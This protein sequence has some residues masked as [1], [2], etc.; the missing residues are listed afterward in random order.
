MS[1][2]AYA[3]RATSREQTAASLAAVVLPKSNS[4]LFNFDDA[5]E[6]FTNFTGALGEVFNPLDPSNGMAGLLKNSSESPIAAIKSTDFA[7]RKTIVD[8]SVTQAKLNNKSKVD[9]R[10]DH[11]PDFPTLAAAQEEADRINTSNQAVIGAKEAAR[12]AIVA[13]FGTAATDSILKLP[14][15][16]TPKGIDKYELHELV[17]AVKMGAERPPVKDVLTQYIETL[18]HC[19]DFRQRVQ[20]NMQ[21]LTTKATRIK[22][23]GVTLDN[24]H[25]AMVIMTNI[26]AA[27][28][29]KWGEDFKQAIS[30]IRGQYSYSYAHDNASIKTILATLATADTARD[31]SRAPAPESLE[32]TEF[33]NAVATTRTLLESI[34]NVGDLES[35]YSSDDEGTAAAARSDSDDEASRRSHRS[36]TKKTSTR[37]REKDVSRGNRSRRSKSAKGEWKKNPCKHCKKFKRNSQH[38]HVR[39]KDC[40]WN[41]NLQVFRPWNVCKEMEIEFIPQH[42]FGSDDEGTTDEE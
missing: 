20:H 36:K 24:T 14:G 7:N 10:E 25:L 1:D 18:T 31:M 29:T 12:D 33:A 32:G 6:F 28:K 16:N 34:M 35:D 19:F 42:K 37:G 2:A 9:G 4:G 17:D 23:F 22:S 11:E 38:P 21:T 30:T 26:E 41:K 5:N 40:F 3:A 8:D 13:Q 27:A 15:T 39:E